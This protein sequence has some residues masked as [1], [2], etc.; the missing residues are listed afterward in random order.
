MGGLV[1]EDRDGWARNGS[2]GGKMVGKKGKWE[3]K[4]TEERLDCFERATPNRY[5][6]HANFDKGNAPELHTYVRCCVHINICI[7]AHVNG[8]GSFN[9][10]PANL[11]GRH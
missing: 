10:Y 3:N 1:G 9:L 5:L 11:S 4:R 2:G 8:E 7:R 6:P